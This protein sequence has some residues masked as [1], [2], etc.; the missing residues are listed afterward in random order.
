MAQ[1][2]GISRPSKHFC[3]KPRCHGPARTGRPLKKKK[4]RTGRPLNQ[5]EKKARAGRRRALPTHPSTAPP[6]PT[7]KTRKSVPPSPPQP[8]LLGSHGTEIFAEPHPSPPPRRRRRMPAGKALNGGRRRRGFPS[9]PGGD[10]ALQ[11]ISPVRGGVLRSEAASSGRGRAARDLG[12]RAQIRWGQPA[13]RGAAL[14]GVVREGWSRPAWA[15]E[16]AGAAPPRSVAPDLFC[17]SPDPW[18]ARLHSGWRWLVACVVAFRPVGN[19][20]RGV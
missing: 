7:T 9:F 19:G 11:G 16:V 15:A 14:A 4:A 13:G 1:Y 18:W 5:K 3:P 8:P 6:P 2:R 20:L 10:T 12:S 17:A